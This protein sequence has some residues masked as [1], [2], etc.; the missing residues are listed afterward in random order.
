MANV[1][2][3]PNLRSINVSIHDQQHD[4]KS[5][6]QYHVEMSDRESEEDVLPSVHFGQSKAQH[7]QS[8]SSD[9]VNIASS[10]DPVCFKFLLKEV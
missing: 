1:Y 8:S 9:A 5:A 7:V 2:T 3:L 10:C 4:E 6:D